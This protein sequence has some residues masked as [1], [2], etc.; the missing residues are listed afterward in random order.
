VSYSGSIVPVPV[1]QGGLLTDLSPDR[2]PPQNL[3]RASNV[4]I[5]QGVIEKSPGSLQWNAT[6][7]SSGIVAC[8]DYW[9]L[10][11]I[12][13]TIA[14]TRDGRVWR[15][16]DKFTV[17]EITPDPSPN[18]TSV[19]GVAPDVL[20]IPGRVQIVE[21]GQEYVGTGG[22]IQPKKLFIF[23]GGSPIQVINGQDT[24]R[25]NLLVPA[26]DWNG[27]LP[28][29]I[30]QAAITPGAQLN[31]S[32]PF[33]GLVFQNRLFV[34]GNQNM[35]HFMYAS[36]NTYGGD[37]F[38]YGNEDFSETTFNSALFNVY[39]GDNDRCQSLFTYKTNLWL[40]KYPRGLYSMIIPDIGDPTT[41][42]FQKVNDDVGTATITGVATVLDDVWV[43]NS[44]GAIQSLV[45]TLN[46]GGVTTDNVLRELQVEKYIQQIT[47]P[48]GVG[49][50]QALWHQAQ[51]TAY[52]L[53]RPKTSQL[54]QLLLAFDLTGSTP[55]LTIITKD[56]PNTLFIRKD[57]SQVDV[58][59]YGS[60]DGYIYL[61]DRANR[62]VG[63]YQ[64]NTGYQGLFETA[65]LP[66]NPST[67]DYTFNFSASN[68]K[69]M[70][71][72]EIEYIP[73]GDITFSCQ[74]L[75][76]GRATEIIEFTLS[77]SNQLGTFILDKSRLQGRSTRRQRKAIHGRGRTVSLKFFDQ[78]NTDNF[79]IT[80]I[81]VYARLGGV[82]EKGNL[83]PA[84][85]DN[86]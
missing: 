22:T 84:L 42:Y 10:P 11:G 28:S 8:Y 82:D 24:T 54:N 15:F 50:R 75:I 2:I 74:V 16:R 83:D 38:Q 64:T 7:L 1:A 37:P 66:L 71:F 13:Y 48:L 70:D 6:P 67:N 69:L 14:V 9:P 32:Y 58:L 43:T 47:S 68:D 23:T 76:D 81:T 36:S 61:M 51:S 53:Y 49:D 78:G 17:V 86:F 63:T 72:V 45:A 41:W 73:T 19:S 29:V 31:T 35:P 30:E 4:Q 34:F 21:G 62:F 77:K 12:Q 46:L 40:L 5:R 39:P 27:Y 56:Q 79:R 80:G 3:L 52:F 65:H 44:V 57:V 26:A 59:A 33:F 20:S 25:H 60:E 18:Y 85:K 55:K